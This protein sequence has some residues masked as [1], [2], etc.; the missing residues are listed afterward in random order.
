MEPSGQSSSIVLR[1]TNEG[2]HHDLCATISIIETTFASLVGAE[3]VG[4]IRLPRQGQ[5]APTCSKKQLDERCS[6]FVCIPDLTFSINVRAKA[7][8]R[9]YCINLEGYEEG[10]SVQ[11]PSIHGHRD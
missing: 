10:Q 5:R 4:R 7:D 2:V 6:L 1:C 8:S 3:D 9:F 11:T